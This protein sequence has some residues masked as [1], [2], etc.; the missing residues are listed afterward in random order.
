MENE[1]CKVCNAVKLWLA[2]PFKPNGSALD[3]FLFFGLIII[4]S[5]LWSR[6]I[7]RIL[8]NT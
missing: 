2:H 1:D 7:A 3:W 5:F 8:I 4:I 6:I